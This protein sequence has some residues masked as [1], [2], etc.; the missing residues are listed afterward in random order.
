MFQAQNYC[1]ARVHEYET[2]RLKSTAGTGVGSVLLT[3]SAILNPAALPFFPFS[4]IYL[5]KGS[6]DMTG[7]SD[8]TMSDGAYSE[9]SDSLGVIVADGSGNLRGAASYLT[10]SEGKSS[11]KRVTAAMGKSV[12]KSSSMGA[13][14]RYTKDQ[15]YSP[16]SLTTVEENY[17]QLVFGAT[18][19]IES[20]FSVGVVV[21]D[22]FRSYLGDTRAIVGTQYVIK[23]ILSLML[24]LGVD[25]SN[26]T[27]SE[28]LLYKAAMQVNFFSDLYLRAGLFEDNNIS[29]KGNGLGIGWIGPKLVLDFGLKY[30]KPMTQNSTILM[31]DE[32]IRETSFAL[33]YKF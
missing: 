20:N 3:E 1:Y 27:L 6:V 15:N 4:T 8:K 10:Q 31:G 14:F 32:K 19:V 12:G 28:T 11:R 5:Q 13:I 26:R 2:T 22:P 23:D 9:A 7:S 30:S 18:H 16:I 33:T 25:Y 17:Q 29:E 21:I 24:D